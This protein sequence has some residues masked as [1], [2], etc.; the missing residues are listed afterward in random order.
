MTTAASEVPGPRIPSPLQ[1]VVGVLWPVRAR[2]VMRER[3]GKV[4]RSN[5][6]I[7]GELF[8]I[9]ERDLVAQM[10]KWKPAYYQVR[11]P[12]QVIEP[13]TGPSSILLLDGDRHL[14]M[15]KLTLP[16]FHGEA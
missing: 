6:S 12:R 14:R 8:H 15:R 16:P 1:T 10:L 3:Y 5:D 9:A 7:A 13:V 11:E 2:L 4:F